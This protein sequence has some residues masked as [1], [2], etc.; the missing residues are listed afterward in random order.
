ML[1]YVLFDVA[2]LLAF[3]VKKLKYKQIQTCMFKNDTIH[4]I[5][6]IQTLR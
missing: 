3:E 4:G 2:F 5:L 1:S 6:E